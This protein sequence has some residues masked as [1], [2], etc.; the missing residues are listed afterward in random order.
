MLNFI[1]DSRLCNVIN[2]III[3]VIS[4]KVRTIVNYVI[5]NSYG[6]RDFVTSRRDLDWRINLLDI[7]QS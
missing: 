6:P 2:K 7:L 4:L 1:F 5:Y 3:I